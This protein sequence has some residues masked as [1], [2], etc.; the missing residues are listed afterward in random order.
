[1]DCIMGCIIGE[2]YFRMVKVLPNICNK[3]NT[4][5]LQELITTELP[6]IGSV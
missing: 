6:Q 2:F 5:C 3:I 4:M 1:M